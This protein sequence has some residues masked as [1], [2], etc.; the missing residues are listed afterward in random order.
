MRYLLVDTNHLASRCRH[1]VNTRDLCRSD[2]HRSAVVHGVIK[3]VSWIRNKLRIDENRILCFWDAGRSQRRLELFPA[4]KSGRQKEQPT[5]EE[6]EERKQYYSQVDACIEG[7][8]HTGIR[9]IRVAGTEADDLIA[10]Y[11][12]FYASIGED[13]IVYSGDGD[14]HQLASPSI[15]IFDPEKELLSEQQILEHWG[16]GSIHEIAIVKA[17]AGDTSDAIPGV[18]QV[19]KKRATLVAPYLHLVL[20]DAERP[21]GIPDST[22]KWI[23][24]SRA[25]FDIVIRNM[26]LMIL[27]TDFQNSYY[28]REQAEQVVAQV[29]GQGCVKSM[30]KF[31]SFCRDWELASVLENIHHWQ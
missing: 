22:W 5:P 2:G 14:L 26:R 24:V 4:Y 15:S 18:P 3:G 23:E 16:V 30:R 25:H 19:G 9:Q 13:V 27:P 20:S 21:S 10:I 29:A 8:A 11:A 17:I 7:L 28:T 12:R 31:M 6:I 1:V